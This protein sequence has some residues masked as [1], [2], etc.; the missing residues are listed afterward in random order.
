MLYLKSEQES[1]DG[2]T[3]P[4][5]P[6]DGQEVRD[7]GVAQLPAKPR[8]Q[9]TRWKRVIKLGGLLV[10]AAALLVT[11]SVLLYRYFWLAFRDFGPTEPQDYVVPVSPVRGR[12]ILLGT[13]IFIVGDSGAN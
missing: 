11:P 1:K 4:L 12:V 3:E 2:E 7:T 10:F 9:F 8:C 13:K 6:S 5:L